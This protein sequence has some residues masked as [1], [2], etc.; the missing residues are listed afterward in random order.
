VFASQGNK[1]AP[2]SGYALKIKRIPIEEVWENRR[3]SYG[4]S[5]EMLC[6]LT[7]YVDAVQSGKTS[8]MGYL[9]NPPSITFSSTVPGLSPQEQLIQDQ[10][11]LRY[12]LV[13]PIDLYIRKHPGMKREDAMEIIKRNQ[14]ENTQLGVQI[15]DPI[16]TSGADV[17]AKNILGMKDEEKSLIKDEEK[18]AQQSATKKP[19]NYKMKKD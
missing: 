11:E 5:Y 8:S 10:F 17:V 19:D 6:A 2:Q 7:M 9:D 13:T 15:Y 3:L 4:P 18:Q 1:G 14:E 12:N 16:N